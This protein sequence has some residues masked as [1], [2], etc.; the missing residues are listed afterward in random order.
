MEKEIKQSLQ[1]RL[2]VLVDKGET[3]MRKIGKGL[4]VLVCVVGLVGMFGCS[5]FQDILTPCHINEAAIE[6]AGIPGTS[7]MPWTSVWD[8]SRVLSHMNYNH[9]V[10]QISYER[11]KQDDN[12][13]H[14]FL[15]GNL[16]V[17]IADARS[18]QE[19]LFDPSGPIGLA[20]PML[21]GG[22]L[23]A[24][25]INTPKKKKEE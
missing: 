25:F 6:Y 12:L 7:Y 17:N 23:G 19:Q 4:V 5:G 15:Y 2:N 18:F 22:T 14:S 1:L 21:F 24:L 10:Y 20:I 13:Q 9:S 16:E 8:A 3:K 11:M